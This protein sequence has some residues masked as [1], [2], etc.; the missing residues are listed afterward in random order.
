MTGLNDTVHRYGEALVHM[1]GRFEEVRAL[2]L[3]KVLFVRRG[4]NRRG[5][6]A[7][8]ITDVEAGQLFDLLPGQGT[9]GPVQWLH[10]QG[11]DFCARMQ[12]ATLDISG[13]YRADFDAMVPG[14]T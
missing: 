3:D 12:R 13:A 4:V 6:F 8:S 7:T 5:E 14:T 11:L 2:G 10:D 9:R 1:P